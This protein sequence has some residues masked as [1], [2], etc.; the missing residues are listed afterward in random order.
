[1]TFLRFLARWF[2]DHEGLRQAR[3]AQE[4]AQNRLVEAR[5]RTREVE[6]A[7]AWARTTRVNNHLT[8]TFFRGLRG[9]SS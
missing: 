4:E 1:M 9:G 8:E 3:Q 6:E 5:N 2:P 7:V